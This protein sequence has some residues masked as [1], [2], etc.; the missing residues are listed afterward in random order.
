[1]SNTLSC[2]SKMCCSFP[3]FVALKEWITQT[4][5]WPLS[6]T[7]IQVTTCLLVKTVTRELLV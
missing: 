3:F 5:D 1:M 6:W 4:L 7:E 2:T